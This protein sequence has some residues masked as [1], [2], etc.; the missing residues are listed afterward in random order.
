MHVN[1]DLARV[2]IQILSPSPSFQTAARA[3]V[4]ND[5]LTHGAGG[6][7]KK[8][9][10]ILPAHLSGIH[11]LEV[12][13]VNQAGC[14]E[15]V[16]IRSPASELSSGNQSKLGIDELEEIIERSRRSVLIGQESGGNR[17]AAGHGCDARG[18]R[19]RVLASFAA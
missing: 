5:D 4:I 17:L 11:E 6:N 15:D 7:A 8:M 2:E 13:L 3:R 18:K 12:G 19:C 1:R 14:V 16:P 10:A 9:I